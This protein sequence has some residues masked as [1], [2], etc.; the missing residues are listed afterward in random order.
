MFRWEAPPYEFWDE[1]MDNLDEVAEL[2]FEELS[3][4]ELIK[5]IE[6]KKGVDILSYF[7]SNER[8]LIET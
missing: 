6:E 3:T 1:V 4:K 8:M 5:L 7:D 2:V